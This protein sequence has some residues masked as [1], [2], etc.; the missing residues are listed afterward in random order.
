MAR[1]KLW[2]TLSCGW[3]KSWRLDRSY[4]RFHPE[5]GYKLR[6]IQDP[7]A[8][9]DLL[10]SYTLIHPVNLRTYF[11]KY[12]IYIVCFLPDD[13]S[14]HWF[15]LWLLLQGLWKTLKKLEEAWRSFKALA[16]TD[17]SSSDWFELRRLIRDLRP[18]NYLQ[19]FES[20]PPLILSRASTSWLVSYNL[21]SCKR[22][23][24]NHVNKFSY[25]ATIL[26]NLSVRHNAH[27]RYLVVSS[28]LPLVNKYAI[29]LDS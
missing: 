14:Y 16:S 21:P 3:L 9:F 28:L 2:L 22:C 6:L 15:R 7:P 13:F 5:A 20:D 17:S 1:Y 27:T 10:L 26:L 25:Y 18:I 8:G 24:K 11:A 12:I 23:S 29:Y 4:S 19:N